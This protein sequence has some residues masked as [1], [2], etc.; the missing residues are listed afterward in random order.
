MDWV[1]E[2]GKSWKKEYPQLDV[3]SLSPLVRLARLGDLIDSI[4]NDVLEPFELTTN[5]YGVL[6]ALQRAGD[7]THSARA[8]SVANCGALRAV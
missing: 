5:D 4:Q 2:L 8:S 7:P 3:S 1:E 6:A